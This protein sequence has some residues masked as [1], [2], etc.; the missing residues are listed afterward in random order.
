MVNFC[1]L[2]PF[3]NLIN[4]R[5]DTDEQKSKT[6][7]QFIKLLAMHTHTHTSFCVNLKLPF[8]KS[9]IQR[10]RFS[11][12]LAQMLSSCWLLMLL[13]RAKQSCS[14]HRVDPFVDPRDQAALIINPARAH[15][16]CLGLC[17]HAYLKLHSERCFNWRVWHNIHTALLH[18]RK[19]RNEMETRLRQLVRIRSSLVFDKL[20]YRWRMP[21][22]EMT[23]FPLGPRWN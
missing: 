12:L 4:C 10:R 14:H 2:T 19:R 6:S 22:L 17:V 23:D 13:Q 15:S 11:L 5:F 1:L 16:L 3:S 8:G 18:A 20:I 9:H 7:G 21:Q